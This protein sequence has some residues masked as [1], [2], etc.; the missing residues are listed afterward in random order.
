MA[1]ESAQ[2]YSL[3]GEVTAR[4]CRL[5]SQRRVLIE[6]IE[7]ASEHLDAV[8]LLNLARKRDARINRATVYRTLDLLKRLRLVDELD[9]MHLSGEK[10]YYEVRPSRRHIHLACCCCGAITEVNSGTFDR[11]QSE[12]AAGTGFQIEVARLEIGGNCRSCAEALRKTVSAPRE[13]KEESKF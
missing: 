3:L 13:G 11:L 7:Q 12:I 5:T 10:H 8:G 2:N 4:G 9:L 1:R 6:I